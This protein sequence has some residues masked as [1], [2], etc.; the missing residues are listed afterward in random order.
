MYQDRKGILHI[1]K[2]TSTLSDYSITQDNSYS[3][4]ETS[5]SKPCKQIVVPT[6]SYN[7]SDVVELFK[8]SVVVNGTSDV[9]INYSEPAVNINVQIDINES[10]ANGT[11]NSAV[12]YANCCK[13][14]ITANGRIALVVSGSA[15]KSSSV[16]TVIPLNT[17]GDE[18]Q[19]VNP[20][21][22]DVTRASAVG[23]WV[24]NYLSNRQTLSYSWRCDPRLDGLDIIHSKDA[25]TDNNVIMTKVSY[26]Y[27]GAFRGTG[28][29]RVV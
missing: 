10:E 12:F 13:L 28:E 15:L 6:Y 21:I 26:S 23:E 2:L 8:G 7:P 25:F 11:I 14:N 19:V 18:I 4:P 5:L 3:K 16:D 9:L 17:T 27:N 22:T 20:L 1:E 29:G 24:K